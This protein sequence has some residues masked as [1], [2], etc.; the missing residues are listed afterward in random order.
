VNPKILTHDPDESIKDISIRMIF[1][2]FFQW[3]LR[4]RY[5]RYLIGDGKMTH[6]D[7]YINYKDREM[8]FL[9]LS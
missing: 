9:I 7:K 8:M 6:K 4:N 2:T 3:F 1:L 5:I